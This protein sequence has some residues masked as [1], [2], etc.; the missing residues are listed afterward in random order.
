MFKRILKHQSSQGRVSESKAYSILGSWR[1][2]SG[3]LIFLLVYLWYASNRGIQI[4]DEGVL[5]TGA[6][7]VLRGGIP[8]RDF[9]NTYGPGQYYILAG[10]FKLFGTTMLTARAYTV[11]SEWAVTILSYFI[12]RRLTGL[13]GGLVSCITVCVWLNYDRFVLYPMVPAL[14]FVLAGYLILTCH[15]TNPR[16]S[17]AAGLL[18][19][20]AVLVR[21]DLGVYAFAGQSAIIFGDGLFIGHLRRENYSSRLVSTIK[22][23]LALSIGAAAVVLPVAF[24]LFR[25]VPRQFLYEAF[26]DFPRRIYPQFRSVPVATEFVRF[27]SSGGIRERV[28]QFIDAVVPLLILLLPVFVFCMTWIFVVMGWK[29]KERPLREPWLAAGLALFGL[30]LY[31]SVRVR[32]DHFHMVAAVA[33]S[34]IL[35]PWLS[36]AIRAQVST[37]WVSLSLRLILL[38]CV[39]I[40][41]VKGLK[42]KKRAFQDHDWIPIAGIDRA[43]G[44]LVPKEEGTSGLTD[45]I[46]YVQLKTAPGEFIFVGNRR[47]DLIFMNSA[48]FY[49]L[50]DRISATRYIDMLPGVVTT[51]KVQSEIINDLKRHDVEYVVLCTM[52]MPSD[53]NKSSVSSGV[54]ILDDFV[55]TN[56]KPEAEFGRYSILH[57]SGDSLGSGS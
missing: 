57:R 30:G 35:F 6:E 22:R 8:Y 43:R 16:L 21:H 19:G 26:I 41:S 24:A 51:A 9:W 4:Y 11:V 40:L 39:A 36:G 29:K 56:Y 50:S 55:R 34:L 23:F 37:R 53:P 28:Y 17:A 47:H 20:C 33:I 18:L 52:P 3:L 31:Y 2:V 48:L 15:P 14:V 49:F 38:F 7:T 54:T 45:A 27:V 13:L 12:G 5:L 42:E 46:K 10:L 32:P 1:F 44:I 25:T